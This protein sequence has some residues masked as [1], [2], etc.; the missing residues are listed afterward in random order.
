LI[1]PNRSKSC[2][3]YFAVDCREK[4][5]VGMDAEGLQVHSCIAPTMVKTT[6]PDLQRR[7]GEMRVEHCD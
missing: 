6:P 2:T 5:L 4:D 1:Y 7:E 3:Y